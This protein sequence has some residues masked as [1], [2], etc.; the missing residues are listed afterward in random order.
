M[1]LVFLATVIWS[2]SAIVMDRLLLQYH[3]TPM[4]ISFWRLVVALPVLAITVSAR[5]PPDLHLDRRES[6]N[7]A[8]L[9]LVGIALFLV[10]WAASVEF[11]RAAVATV[12]IYSAPAFVAIVD[13]IVFDQRLTAAQWAA[14]AI[15]LLGC[16]LVTGLYHFGS[17]LLSPAGAGLG[18]ATGLTFAAY[19]L[20]GKRVSGSE[21]H[22]S[23]T[24]L[25]YTFL[26]GFLGIAIPGFALAGPSLVVL[27]LDA[28]GWFLVAYLGL[29]PTLSGYALYNAGLRY[30]S[31]SV[32]ALIT[33]L[34]PVM[35]AIFAVIFLG[36]GMQPAQWLG[37]VLIV[38]GVMVMQA[39]T[40]RWREEP[41]T[42][43]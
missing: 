18:L 36:R 37:T 3:M 42:Q 17:L 31:A 24:I 5:Q 32:A 11:N 9:G 41:S 10:L 16:A 39:A 23:L 33:T 22:G 15:D 21:R 34:E 27:H 6:P 35:T 13:R 40:V 43:R 2:T 28:T 29:G 4:Q 7:Y 8:V 38:G 19:T 26:F 25:S 30:V 20:L 12:L 1:A 14:V